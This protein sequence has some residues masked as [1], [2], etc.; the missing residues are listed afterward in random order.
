MHHFFHHVI[1]GKLT[2]SRGALE[3]SKDMEIE[4]RYD[5]RLGARQLFYLVLECCVYVSVCVRGGGELPPESLPLCIVVEIT[6]LR[7]FLSVAYHFIF[8]IVA[9]CLP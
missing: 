7:Y 9:P 3:D 6:D 8:A 5:S 4:R 1:I 2:T